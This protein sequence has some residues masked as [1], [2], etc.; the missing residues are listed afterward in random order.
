MLKNHSLSKSISDA[1]YGQFI[2]KAAFKAKIL[3][4]HFIAVDPWGTSQFCSTCLQ[5]VPKT[6]A[7]REHWCRSCGENLPRDVNSAK[8]I[9]RLGILVKRRRLC[10]SPDRGSSLAEQLPLPSLR[11]MVSKSEEAGSQHL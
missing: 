5:W 10:P 1:S 3:G 9:K 2:A 4:K 7:E 8:L 11:G 6:L